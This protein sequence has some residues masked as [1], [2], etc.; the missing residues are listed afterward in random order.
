[1]VHSYLSRLQE[2]PC[3]ATSPI[4]AARRSRPCHL[5]SPGHKRVHAWLPLRFRPRESWGL[6]TS[7]VQATKRSMPGYLSIYGWM[8]IQAWLPLQSRSRSTL[9]FQFLQFRPQEG[10]YLATPP[11]KATKGSRPVYL[12]NPGHKRVHAR[13][14]LKSRPHKGPWL[15]QYWTDNAAIICDHTSQGLHQCTDNL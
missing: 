4:K 11:L 2:T 13:L 10:L 12:Y 1:M 15:A 14:T 8:I 6:V 3:L 7:P 9:S 5:S